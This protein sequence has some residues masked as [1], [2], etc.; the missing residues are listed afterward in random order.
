MARLIGKAPLWNIAQCAIFPLCSQISKQNKSL[1]SCF[2]WHKSL[3]QMLRLVWWT[4]ELLGACRLK[5][6]EE[7]FPMQDEFLFH[8]V[9]C[10]STCR[11]WSHNPGVFDCQCVT[12]KS[13]QNQN[14]GWGMLDAGTMQSTNSCAV[15]LDDKKHR[16]V[17]RKLTR[18]GNIQRHSLL[19]VVFDGSWAY[20]RVHWQNNC[21]CTWLYMHTKGLLHA[22]SL[23]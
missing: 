11:K 9:R 2:I 5:Q 10:V 6:M 16:N 17:Q 19:P 18:P 14:H 7:T 13:F 23:F 12:K 3:P 15:C 20:C 1:V 8:A 21:K 22:D 4:A